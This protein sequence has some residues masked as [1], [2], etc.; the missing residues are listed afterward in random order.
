MRI[1][2]LIGLFIIALLIYR[3]YRKVKKTEMPD[4]EDV[5]DIPAD[6]VDCYRKNGGKRRRQYE[7]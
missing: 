7:T 4:I 6:I 2:S 3:A 5:R 1:F